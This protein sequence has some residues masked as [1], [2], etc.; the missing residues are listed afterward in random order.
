MS[1]SRDHF[2]EKLK[3]ELQ[4]T[5][6]LLMKSLG[7]H[8][9]DLTLPVTLTIFQIA[10]SAKSYTAPVRVR[11][12]ESYTTQ[13][14]KR[15]IEVQIGA[16]DLEAHLVE[17]GACAFD[18]V[19]HAERPLNELQPALHAVGFASMVARASRKLVI[20]AIEPA[21]VMAEPVSM[22]LSDEA[23]QARATSIQPIPA[24]S[25]RIALEEVYQR[26]RP[27]P[28]PLFGLPL[29]KIP[30]PPHRFSVALKER[31]KRTLAEKNKTH[32]ANIQLNIIFDKMDMSL[33][34][35]ISQD[36]YGHLLCH[37]K[38]EHLG[39]NAPN[40]K[41][42]FEGAPAYLVFGTRLD[43]GESVK[44]LVPIISSSSE[45]TLS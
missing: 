7:H 13:P 26:S 41:T 25:R 36:E 45:E 21:R 1:G 12:P 2:P 43:T 32:A 30:V 28:S 24:V 16:L 3:R 23:A 42:R 27:I 17:G 11:P 6:M 15:S 33:F 20:D 10:L 4:S 34:A 22:K 29:R 31:F 18:V 39:K 9:V 5:L 37:P 19:T 44:A 40:A 14:L 38:P 8:A 35:S